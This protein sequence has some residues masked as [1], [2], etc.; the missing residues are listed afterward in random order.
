M[1]KSMKNNRQNNKSNKNN[2]KKNNVKAV[3][4]GTKTGGNVSFAA[5]LGAFLCECEKLGD[6]VGDDKGFFSTKN[7]HKVNQRVFGALPFLHL[8]ITKNQFITLLNSGKLNLFNATKGMCNKAKLEKHL[9]QV[10]FNCDSQ[11]NVGVNALHLAICESIEKRWDMRKNGRA[12]LN[13]IQKVQ[14]SQASQKIIPQRSL[15]W[16][17]KK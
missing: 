11:S 3:L 6:V 8:N 2:S 14:E 17:H 9:S 12:V 4:V 15:D 13:K 10:K 16:C 1:A 5:K 7:G